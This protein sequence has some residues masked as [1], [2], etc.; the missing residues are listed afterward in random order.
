MENEFTSNFEVTIIV[1]LYSEDVTGM[2][3]EV[4]YSVQNVTKTAS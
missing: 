1:G 4:V 3:V 2:E